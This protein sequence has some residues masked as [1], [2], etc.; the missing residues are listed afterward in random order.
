MDLVNVIRKVQR[1]KAEKARSKNQAFCFLCRKQVSL[2]SF[3]QAT[4]L[5]EALR[6]RITKHLEENL[7]HRIHNSSGEVSICLSS[8]EEAER[9]AA[10]TLPLRAEF[11]KR[12]SKMA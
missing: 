12:V 5:D 3:Q 7:I 1:K 8:V 6:F 9:Q 4:K 11:L 2:L 10:D